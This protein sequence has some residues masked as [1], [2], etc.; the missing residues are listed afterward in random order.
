MSAAS[1]QGFHCWTTHLGLADEG[2]D[3]FSMV[4]SDRPCTSS[5]VFTKS[6]FAGPCVTLSKTSIEQTSPRGVLVLAKNAN[7]ATGA[8]GLRN[9]TEIRAS[10]AR[11]VGIEP[12]ALIMAS[13]GVI[14]V[15]YP[16]DTIRTG[17]DGLGQGT[18][19]DA[20]AVARAIMTTDTRAKVSERT[21]GTSTSTIVGIAKGVGMIEPDMATMLSF[22]FTDADVPQNT[23]DRIF[24]DVVDRTYNS[25]SIDTDTS[26]SDT[27]AIF[28]NGAA[29]PVPDT[30][31]EQA[32]EEVCTEL[33]KMI[34][35]DG[36]GATKLIVTTVSGASSERQART[37]GKSI[38]NSP[39]VKT[40]IHGEDPNWGRVLMA[41]G[42]CSSEVDIDP[43]K[44]RVAF[45]DIDVYPSSS[46]DQQATIEAVRAHLATA[47]VE[48]NID[49]GIGTDAWTV[50]GCDLTDG[51]IRINADYTT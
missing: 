12:N 5:V 34:A 20:H 18:P 28:A 4:I 36:E 27:A 23:L 41:I 24:R 14:G 17:L 19:L 42:K 29:G 50:F 3:D 15:Q 11:T 16:M 1:P 22:V 26:T 44:V 10:V 37:V 8:E 2:R 6:L 31:F 7:V 48:I 40:M 43:G 49:L 45:A 13:T 51:Y 47:T 39:L 25:V 46:L 9:A 30:E 32:L 21:V 35:S 33:V 38:I